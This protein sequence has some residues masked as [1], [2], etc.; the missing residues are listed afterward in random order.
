M[1]CYTVLP[2]VIVA[3]YNINTTD[4]KAITGQGRAHHSSQD[5]SPRKIIKLTD[6]LAEWLTLSLFIMVKTKQKICNKILQS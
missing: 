5:S 6:R 2:T 3:E 4:C 1:P